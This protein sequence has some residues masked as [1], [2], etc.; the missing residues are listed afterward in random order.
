MVLWVQCVP[1]TSSTTVE[2]KGKN[3]RSLPT[4]TASHS[5]FSQDSQVSPT[6]IQDQELLTEVLPGGRII[7]EV[8]G[9]LT[10]EWKQAQGKQRTLNRIKESAW[11]GGRGLCLEFK[12]NHHK[13]KT[14]ALF[15]K[16]T[17]NK[18]WTKKKRRKRQR[19]QPFK[20][21]ERTT[22]VSLH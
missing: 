15:L 14:M 4:S 17:L 8:T 12:K 18:N 13:G 10:G 16:R 7:L 2:L 19:E 1:R 21:N 20:S 3:L 22:T 11:P 5:A 6:H 9:A